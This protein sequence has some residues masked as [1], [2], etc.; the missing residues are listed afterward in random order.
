MS[1]QLS[2]ALAGAALNDTERRVIDRIVEILR[3]EL[4]ED[5]LA[6]WLYGSRAR[7]EADPTET[8]PDR[9]SDVDLLVIVDPARDA[10]EFSWRLTPLVIEA[11]EAEGDSP[12]WYSVLVW[13][14]DRLRDRRA[15]R[16][17]FAGEVDRDKIVLAGSALEGADF[18]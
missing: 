9:R 11:V 10:G 4:G 15:I 12:V 7:G 6:V 1:A 5:L 17:F 13:D 16:S 14:A 8:D 18:E 3:V 2:E